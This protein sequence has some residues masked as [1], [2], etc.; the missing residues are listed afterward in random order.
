MKK[1][2]EKTYN[3][4]SVEDR[5]Y[6]NWLEKRYF[7][8]E[9]DESKKP[10]TIVIPPPNITGQLHM[11]HALN[12]TLQDILIRWKR[13]Q[14]YN[15]LWVPGTDHASISTEVRIINKLKEEGITKEDLG[16]E[17][18]LE[19]AWSWREEY[20]GR[21]LQQLKKLGSSCD[22]E[23]ERFTLDE[24][25]SKAVTEVFV[26]LYEK[27]WIYRG[28]KIINWC[29]K[30][31]TTISDAEVDH[32]DMDS[33]FWHLQYK[34]KETGEYIRFATTRPETILADTALAV[35]PVDER[36]QQLVGKTA[37][38]PIV[39]R[40][41]PII[42]DEYVEKDFGTGV[43]KI[44]PSHDPNDYEVGLRHDLPKINLLNDD[45]TMN[46]NAG[47]YKGYDRFEA[48][49]LIVEE[50]KELGALVKEEKI[51]HAVGV[52][53]RCN[54]VVE[55]MVKMQWFVQM[56]EMSRPALNVY[57]AGELKFVPERYGKIYQHW[58]ENIRDWC[59]SRQLWWGHR[60]PAY[61][62]GDCGHINVDRDAPEKCE[63]CGGHSLT[64]DP[65]TLD[66]WF[67]SALW[68]FSTLG[69]PEKT[70]ELEYFYPTDVLVTS[71]DII[72]FWVVRMVFS[73][74]E[75][76]KQK[77]FE[78]VFIN[79]LVRDSQG[80]KMSKSLDNGIDP[81]EVIDKYGADALRLS[82]VLGCAIGNDSRFYWEKVESGRNFL[83]KLW[84]ATRFILMNFDEDEPTAS[85]EQLTS[86]DKWILSRVNRVAAE[87]TENLQNFDLGLGMQ[88]VY[89]FIWDEFCDWY[90]E[91]VKPRLY[92]RD[93][94]TRQAALWT[95]K[96]VLIRAL[97][98]LHP[99]LPF[100]TEE[101]FTSI[102]NCEETIMLSAWPEYEEKYNF[103]EEEK[104]VEL[105]KSAIKGIRNLRAQMNVPPSK[106][107]GLTI[108]SENPR[109]REMFE[110]GKSFLFT[111]GYAS[112]IEI[113]NGKEDIP[114]D[115]LSVVV[116]EAMLYLPFAELVD[117]E[118]E[119]QR[120]MKERDKLIKEVDRVESKLSNPG[121]IAKAPAALIEE[122]R[123]KQSKYVQLL[124]QVEAQI[125]SLNFDK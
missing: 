4:A 68:P 71:Y 88:K 74:M 70:K 117:I 60:I 89:D 104:E 25:L 49:K 110:K 17:G 83:N 124:E 109:V 46:E 113:Q 34:I 98:L 100:I 42:T 99:Y 80:R 95:L 45:G 15:A 18:F 86:T 2:L 114:V 90:I 1:E 6:S 21:I 39:N 94:I 119:K 87:A 59:I 118:K 105:I 36:Y 69:W 96:E 61:Y 111:L 12:N 11:G 123:E 52:H 121:F 41:I 122:E 44:T 7:H 101:I 40:E 31:E 116:P 97:K 53:E 30:C 120:L 63:H 38:V 84:N 55:P 67:S 81:L 57:T 33:S 26:R 27:G 50:L 5:I 8:A 9:P 37:I 51:T 28:E 47:K 115:S 58:L 103:P 107:T 35:N 16:R 23:R 77:P 19:R 108:V 106:K 102:Q 62:C 43:V 29:P 20:G 14:G 82:L 85:I 75:Q 22:W 56:D 3:P 73:G 91:M 79:G 66:T 92:N 112:R 13:M 24:G 125:D 72:F 64:Q 10:F 32:K 65:D 93:D 54:D 48:R 76:M 78:H